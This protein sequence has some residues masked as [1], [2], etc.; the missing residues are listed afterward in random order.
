VYDRLDIAYDDSFGREW[1]IELA[2]DR[3]PMYRS[4]RVETDP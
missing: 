3:S 2:T 4:K 1:W